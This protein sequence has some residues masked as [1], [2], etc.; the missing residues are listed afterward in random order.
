MRLIQ[1]ILLAGFL[2]SLMLYLRYLRSSLR[3]RMIIIVIIAACCAAVI[4]PDLTQEAAVLVGVGRG[5][6]L[7]FYLFAVGVVF[8][9]V[10]MN[11]RTSR[12]HRD[13]TETVRR[14]AI[15]EVEVAETKGQSG[16]SDKNSAARAES[17]PAA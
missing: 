16:L 7:T 1:P 11:S 4:D 6:D 10:L 5:T 8:F 3:D 12:L 17:D 15:V 13:F 2:L 9:A 14:L